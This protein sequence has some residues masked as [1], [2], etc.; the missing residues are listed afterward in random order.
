MP[1]A[2]KLSFGRRSRRSWPARG[3]HLRRADSGE[4][5]G[6]LAGV[7]AQT[8]PAGMAEWLSA[9]TIGEMMFDS[10]ICTCTGCTGSSASY[11][12]FS[13]PSRS[14]VHR[15]RLSSRSAPTAVMETL[16]TDARELGQAGSEAGCTPN[17][18]KAEGRSQASPR[19]ARRDGRHL[20][21]EPN[22][23]RLER[24]SRQPSEGNGWQGVTRWKIIFN[25]I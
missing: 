8:R 21:R 22:V 12:I 25:S 17:A 16:R 15:S 10:R 1:S 2:R 14:D 18:R 3:A 11:P 4:A 6:V 19:C 20:R 9:V 23:L 13:A 5:R 7:C 24:P